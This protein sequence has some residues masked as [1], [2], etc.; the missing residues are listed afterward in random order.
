MLSK[1]SVVSVGFLLGASFS[2]APTGIGS[3][4]AIVMAFSGGAALLG[5]VVFLLLR[6]YGSKEFCKLN[7]PPGPPAAWTLRKAA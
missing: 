5:A 6:K 7:L 1:L 2:T 4:D 3:G